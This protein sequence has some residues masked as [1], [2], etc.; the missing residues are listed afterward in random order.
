MRVRCVAIVR[1]TLAGIDLVDV[2]QHLVRTLASYV[3]AAAD[4]TS[5]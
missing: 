4:E 5:G 1:G 2:G 3:L